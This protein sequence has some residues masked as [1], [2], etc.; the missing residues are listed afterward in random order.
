M[1]IRMAHLFYKPEC[2]DNA[3]RLFEEG[4]LPILGRQNGA[5]AAQLVGDPSG[6]ERIAITVWEDEK[7]YREFLFS[8]D[9]KTITEM[10]AEMYIDDRVPFGYDF[11][12]IKE[13]IF[14][15]LA[16]TP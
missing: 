1:F 9:M 14:K 13:R 7:T 6:N 16:P 3:A 11:P 4:V 8:E 15:S 10:F 2:R 5:V 12:V